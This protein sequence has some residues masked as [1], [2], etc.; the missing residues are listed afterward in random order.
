LIKGEE[1]SVE[2]YEKLLNVAK[3]KLSDFNSRSQLLSKTAQKHV[4]QVS[5]TNE[6]K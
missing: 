2:Y 4:A 5:A 1:E 6:A 3:G